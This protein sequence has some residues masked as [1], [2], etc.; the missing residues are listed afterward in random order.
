MKALIAA[1]LSAMLVP[2]AV[3]AEEA[4]SPTE[5]VATPS[6]TSTPPPTSVLATTPEAE[7]A[8]TGFH[9]D[10]ALEQ[11]VGSGTFVNAD[12]Y[13]SL[14]A[15]LLLIPSYSFNFRGVKLAV[16]ARQ[17]FGFEYLRPANTTGRRFD[18]TD[19][20]LS[21]SA[22]A[23][24]T[25][26][27]TGIAVTPSLSAT[28]PLSWTSRL[29]S[30]ITSLGLSAKLSRSIWRFDLGYSLGGSRG[31]H[32]NPAKVMFTSDTVDAFG[33]KSCIARS[34]AE[35]CSSAG[36]NSAWGLS[37]SF[38]VGFRALEK[39]RFEA[40]YAIA[41]YWT[42]AMPDDAY[43]PQVTDSNGRRV[44]AVGAGRVDEMS[45][46][47]TG[48]YALTDRWAISASIATLRVPPVT[49]DNRALRFPLIDFIG[50]A[51]NKT[52]YSVALEASF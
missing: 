37:N 45:A 18:L 2:A 27:R 16:A 32:A 30:T 25:E 3:F 28:L 38:V 14:G 41:N 10:M 19:T 43:T 17:G 48:T 39:L 36:I 46:S 7:A 6:A 11:Y 52:S 44:A 15:S 24:W 51:D 21:L 42:Y 40:T 23:I 31:I 47:L 13:G 35:A 33:N 1:V 8:Q 26:P 12:F 50:P 22:P 34:G 29:N 9:F 4:S 20:R 5:A 49:A